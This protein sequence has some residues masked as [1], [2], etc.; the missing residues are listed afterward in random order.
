MDS[1]LS[2]SK[3]RYTV[4]DII[5]QG[6]SWPRTHTSVM[7]MCLAEVELFCSAC[8]ATRRTARRANVVK[9]NVVRLKE[10]V[11]CSHPPSQCTVQLRSCTD[12]VLESSDFAGGQDLAADSPLHEEPQSEHDRRKIQAVEG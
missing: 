3:N 11:L 5:I 2:N 4:L 9:H 8:M 10:E 12:A 6:Y 1:T 7:G